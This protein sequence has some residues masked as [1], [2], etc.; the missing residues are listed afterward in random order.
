MGNTKPFANRHDS[1]PGRWSRDTR[2]CS[3]RSGTHPGNID[4]N[5]IDEEAFPLFQVLLKSYYKRHVLP[6]HHAQNRHVCFFKRAIYLYA[7]YA[8]FEEIVKFLSEYTTD[9]ERKLPINPP[10][11]CWYFG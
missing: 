6:I 8:G 4:G 9:F 7:R 1:Y 2:K 5:S 11:D 3:G 10:M